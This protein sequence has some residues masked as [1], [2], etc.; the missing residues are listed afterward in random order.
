MS[1]FPRSTKFSAEKL[2]ELAEIYNSPF[3]AYD[4]DII[5]TKVDQLKNFDV[6]RYAQKACSNINILR[7]MKSLGTKIDSVSPGE[8]ERALNA[9]FQAGTAENEIVFTA[10]VIDNETCKRALE[11]KIPINCGSIDMLKVLG[12][13]KAE[14]HPVWI[15]INPG[16]GQGHSQKTNTGGENSKH[17]IWYEDLPE[18]LA[19]IKQN[20]L[21]LIGFHMHIGSGLF[22]KNFD[23]TCDAMAE[24]VIKC[25]VDIEAI[26]AGGGIP[27]AYKENENDVDINNYYELWNAA[28]KKIEEH[29]GHS[30]TLEIEPGRFLVAESGILVT[31]VLAIKQMGGKKYALI[32]SGF[33]DLMRPAMYGSYHHIT[34]LD[35]TEDRV[36]EEI[37]IA[38]HLCESGDMFTQGE[39]GIVQLRLLPKLHVGDYLIFHDVG[40]YGASMSSNY[41]SWPLLP[42]ILF[43]DGETKLIRR[44]QTI[45][46]LMHLEQI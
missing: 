39:G 20:K 2:I 8:I 21:K 38:G 13:K 14:G 1:K 29:F 35:D 5:K 34:V 45:H 40:A 46:D 30:I 6:I 32:N 10:D 28:R 43:I 27:I 16:F 25:D 24:L 7:L 33:N 15:R 44:K 23:R 17:G 42:E 41:N 31:K 11:L 26:S 3:W 9:G 36:M 4:G 22:S 19:V 18:A 37:V 12:T